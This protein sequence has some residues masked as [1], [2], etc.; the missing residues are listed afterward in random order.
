MEEP[1]VGMSDV[2]TEIPPRPYS[3]IKGSEPSVT[4]ILSTKNTPGLDWAAA[5]VTAER[6][7]YSDEWMS[8]TRNP[9]EE[10][11][12][13]R[14]YFR[15]EWDG[16]AYMGTLLHTVMDKWAHGETADVLTLVRAHKAWDRTPEITD[17]KIA[18]ANG[19]VLGLEQFWTDID[20]HELTTEECVRSSGQFVGQRDMRVKINGEWWLIDL[21]SGRKIY[22]DFALQLAAYRYAP[23]VVTYKWVE[24]MDS[25]GK[26]KA[27]L[28]VDT[29]ELNE[30]VDRCGI[31]H[32][33]GDGTYSL[34]EFYVSLDTY[35]TFLSLIPIY[36]WLKG[37]PAPTLTELGGS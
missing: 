28:A 6:A 19:Y 36:H 37:A 14:R 20:T 31:L 24:S 12:T 21:K 25:K 22:D 2:M 10:V 9:V 16:K 18:E 15:G 1:G 17:V 4:T 13:L 7:V 11:D 26:P 29:V 27:E 32:V 8:P 30:P 3:K 5:K 23:Q 34:N 33:P 35:D